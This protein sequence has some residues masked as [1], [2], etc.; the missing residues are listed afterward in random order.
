MLW[1]F[2]YN[3]FIFI[4]WFWLNNFILFWNFW[5][6]LLNLFNFKKVI[7]VFEKNVLVIILENEIDKWGNQKHLRCN[8]LERSSPGRARITF[9][10]WTTFLTPARRA[11]CNTCRIAGVWTSVN[12]CTG[13]CCL[14]QKEIIKITIFIYYIYFLIRLNN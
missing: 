8:W 1:K 13:C 4:F 11:Y 5:I 7:A 12:R 14:F 2:F 10:S 6:L 3:N 9:V